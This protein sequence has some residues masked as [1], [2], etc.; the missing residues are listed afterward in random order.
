MAVFEKRTSGDGTVTYRAKIRIKGYPAQSKTFDRLTDARRWASRIQ[1][2][3]Q[4]GRACPKAA[5]AKHTLGDLIDRY[6]REFLPKKSEAMQEVQA[7]HLRWWK[8]Q[9]GVYLLS[10]I[11][12]ALIIEHRAKLEQGKV[13]GGSTRCP[14]TCNRYV[15]AL[16]HAFSIA[17]RDWE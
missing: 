12:P 13:H 4:E 16:R 17:V 14:A 9:M 1:A 2:E 10:D 6:I 3:I 15:A 5:A 8:K 7:H 11:T